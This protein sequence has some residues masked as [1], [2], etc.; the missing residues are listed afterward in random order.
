MLLNYENAHNSNKQ[1]L[2][3]RQLYD[4]VLLQQFNL[5]VMTFDMIIIT[6]SS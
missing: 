5:F 6:D 3:C 1:T 2:K 4:F